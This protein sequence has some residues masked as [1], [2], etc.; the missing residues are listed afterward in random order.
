[1]IDVKAYDKDGNA[2]ESIQVD[3]AWFGGTVRKR[4]L[5][6]AVLMYEASLRTG[7]AS[8]LRRSEVATSSRK[9]WR[10]KHTGRARV[11]DR[12][13][14]HR[15]G[16]ASVFGPRPRDYRYSLPKKALKAAL[17]SAILAKLGDG[18][19]IVAD[20]RAGETPK[21]KPVA[22]YFAKIGVQPCCTCLYVT[23]DLNPVFYKS[24]RNISGLSISPLAQINA[25]S[26]VKPSLIVFSREAF[27]KLLEG[28]R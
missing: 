27:E 2:T 22:E 4:A 5:R 23:G 13:A 8:T 24:A 7:T 26:V 21:T 6:E 14:P 11:G 1:M 9:L 10:Q 19:V 25:Y 20:C 3:E 15:R 17:D 18:Q 28:R 16:G 12:S